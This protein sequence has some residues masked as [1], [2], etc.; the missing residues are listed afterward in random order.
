MM[1]S[2]DCTKTEKMGRTA[3]F[4]TGISITTG[5]TVMHVH[6]HACS[7]CSVL[8]VK[9]FCAVR[10]CR[11]SGACTKATWQMESTVQIGMAILAA[12]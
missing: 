3:M 8:V 5:R 11:G 7:I 2:G 10:T 4:E 1:A 9:F 6:V 12:M